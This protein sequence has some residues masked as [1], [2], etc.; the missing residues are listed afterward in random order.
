MLSRRS[1]MTRERI[2]IAKRTAVVATV[3][4][5]C[6]GCDQAT[7]SLAQARLPEA[8]IWSFL[9]DTV[10]LQLVHNQ[11]AF[12]SLGEALP[13]PW[14]AALLIGGVGLGLLGLLAYAVLSRR[15]HAATV[16]GVALVFAGG[17]SN[18]ADRLLH[19]GGVVDFLNLGLGSLRTGIFNVA[20]VAIVA[21][22][23]CLCA[24]RRR[25]EPE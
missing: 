2:G 12:L 22:A 6:V 24:Q 20:D 18:L 8:E 1:R 14:R 23:L 9:G 16:V 4:L 5:G 21:G 25:V 10:R 7:K 3:I 15:A 13:E 11:G 19:A 17:A